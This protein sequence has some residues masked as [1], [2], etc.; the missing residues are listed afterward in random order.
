VTMLRSRKWNCYLS[1]AV[2]LCF[3]IAVLAL[4]AKTLLSQVATPVT[5]S[6]LQTPLLLGTAWYPE[7]VG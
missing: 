4:A 3:S 6:A 5:Y 2:A 1:A 7:H